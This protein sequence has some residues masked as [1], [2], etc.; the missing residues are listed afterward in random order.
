MFENIFQ[1]RSILVTGHTGFKG[2]WLALWLY[3]LGA[4]VTG[5][6]LSPNTEPSHFDVIRLQDLIAHIEGDIREIRAKKHK[7]RSAPTRLSLETNNMMYV[8]YFTHITSSSA[9]ILGLR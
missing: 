2:S 5:L 8:P 6:A 9:K 7:T 4:R 1:N 3:E